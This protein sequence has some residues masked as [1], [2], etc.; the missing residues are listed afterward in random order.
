MAQ[1]TDPVPTD[2]ALT[3]ELASFFQVYED[4]WNAQDLGALRTYWDTDD[5]APMY[6]AEEQ[7]DWRIGWE[8]L[9]RY[10]VN[11]PGQPSMIEAVWMR[12]R[13]TD[14]KLLSPDLVQVVGWLRHDMKMRGPMK[15][16]GGDARF[17]AVLRRKPEGWR[18]V[19]YTEAHMTPLRYVQ[20]LYE[21]DVD[22]AFGDFHRRVTEQQA[23]ARRPVTLDL[24]AGAPDGA[25]AA[26]LG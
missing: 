25:V 24:H 15:A 9:D 2:P 7:D 3:A 26:A 13:L 4:V 8:Q 17:T 14:A 1:P 22:P 5:A 21:K 23:E 18:F 20:K 12:Y 16:W 19:T 6:L 11:N 10:F